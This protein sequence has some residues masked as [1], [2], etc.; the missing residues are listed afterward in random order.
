MAKIYKW[1]KKGKILD[2]NTL[3]LP[4]FR[5]NTMTP[6]PY[7]K[8]DC[9]RIFLTM[10]DEQ[11]RGQV[12]F[13]DVDPE[14]PAHIMQYSRIPSL[15]L[16]EK[17]MFDED[18]VLP[19][20]LLKHDGRLYLH[21]SAYQKQRTVPYTIF[22]GLAVSDNDGETF[23]RVSKVPILDRTDEELFQ[24]SAVEIMKIG[25]RYRIWYTSGNGWIDRG[26]K[27]APCYDIKCLESDRFDSFSGTP[28]S[29]LELAAGHDEYG[30]TM[31]QV[32]YQD[33]MFKM[34]YS[35][36]SLS[37]GYRLGYAEST[38]G[39]HFSRMDDCMDIDVSDNGFDSEMICFG[40]MARWG[41]RTFL[42]Y[43][44]NHYGRGGL[45]YAEL[46]KE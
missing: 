9:I 30:L 1:D 8:K 29:S 19:T 44:G 5:L 35:V 37:K 2:Y 7:V 20:S 41:S 43:C 39:I 40:K 12:G 11:N 42:F 34:L 26:D 13:I 3:G 6:L 45:G 27:M 36:R 10:C 28:S 21:Y 33:N 4:W 16:G 24:R 46:I 14:N 38:D 23:T 15:G 18:G 22:S 17:G 32:W 31:P 25:S